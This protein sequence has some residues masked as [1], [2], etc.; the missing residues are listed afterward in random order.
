MPVQEHTRFL[1]AESLCRLRVENGVLDGRSLIDH[2]LLHGLTVGLHDL[3]REHDGPI[4]L[5]LHGT[6]CV[7]DS[8]PAPDDLFLGGL[9]DLAPL[10]CRRNFVVD[11]V[12]VSSP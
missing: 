4:L 7:E 5:T 3:I 1:R 10:T 12:P 8:V 11:R 9:V 2:Y 6:C